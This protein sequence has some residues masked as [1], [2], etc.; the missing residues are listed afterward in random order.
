MA[1]VVSWTAEACSTAVR[2]CS[3]VVAASWVAVVVMVV[4]LVRTVVVSRLAIH[5]PRRRLATV[6]MPAARQQID[7]LFLST[8]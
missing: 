2:S 4:I 3:S 7:F 6:A 1:A 5:R 8:V